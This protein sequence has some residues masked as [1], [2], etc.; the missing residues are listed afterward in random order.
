M[1]RVFVLGAQRQ[2]LD[3][4]H[5]TGRACCRGAGGRPSWLVCFPLAVCF[6]AAVQCRPANS[7]LRLHPS[8]SGI[9]GKST[10]ASALTVNQRTAALRGLL[11]AG[12]RGGSAATWPGKK[13]VLPAVGQLAHLPAGGFAGGQDGRL[14]LPG[15]VVPQ[16][17]AEIRVTEVDDGGL[18]LVPIAL[19]QLAVDQPQG[20]PGHRV[21]AWAEE[22]PPVGLGRHIFRHDTSPWAVLTQAECMHGRS[23]ARRFACRARKT[24]VKLW[25]LPAGRSSKRTILADESAAPGRQAGKLA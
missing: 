5:P 6:A 19:L 8:N 24:C 17:V 15:A 12:R 14:G 18:A 13:S 4:C 7:S 25:P 1:Q 23:R 10:T 9:Q 16:R 3:P 22:V 11:S 2:P 20:G 21:L